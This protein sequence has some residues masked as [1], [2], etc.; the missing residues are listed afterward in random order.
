MFARHSLIYL[1]ARGVPSIIA[2]FSVAIFTRLLNPTEFGIYSLV[3]TSALLLSSVFFQWLRMGLLRFYQE[4]NE[5]EQ[6]VLVS[7]LAVTFLVVAL[8]LFAMA[9][10]VASFFGV[11]Q[12]WV[13]LTTSIAV[14]Q[15]GFDILL[16]RS[17][18]DL[19]P[20][21]YGIV[22]FLRA[23]AILIGGVAGFEMAGVTGLLT[24]L[25]FGLVFIVL[26]ELR[27]SLPLIRLRL[28]ERKEVGPLLRY[29]LPLTATFALA[30][31]MGFSDRYMLAWMQDMAT[32]GQYA[33]AYDI[34]QKVI[35]TLMMVVNLAGYP[36]ILHAQ[37]ESGEERFRSLLKQTL[38]GLLLI[39]LPVTTAFVILPSVIASAL[40][41]EAF[42]AQATLLLPWLAAAALLEGV[43]VYYFDL[44]FQLRQNT[45]HQMWIVVLAAALNVA[46]NFWLI[47]IYGVFGA[48]WATLLANASALLLSY[49]ISRSQVALPLYTRD[50]IKILAAAVIMTGILLMTRTPLANISPSPFIQLFVNALLGILVYSILC[51][52][53]NV[54]GSQA[55]LRLLV[56]KMKR[57]KKAREL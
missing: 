19:S 15:G 21:R 44:S 37:A 43:K 34:T 47:P 1:L 46:L 22:S 16:E 12:K 49:A 45:L 2:F 28:A 11:A 57:T 33:A 26:V 32:A 53:L 23:L 56:I 7:T 38:N 54:M 41:G 52:I 35:I 40:L 31:V 50:V 39:G 24:G 36:L 48:A 55:F 17:R 8:G 3:Y 5:T 29:G 51:I 27:R 6:I 30:G 4:R 13:V 14:V 9:L 25:L 18:V 10:L 20:V 42:Q